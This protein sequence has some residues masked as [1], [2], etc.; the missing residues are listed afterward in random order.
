MISV[1]IYMTAY[2]LSNT[3]F[4]SLLF[5]SSSISLNGNNFSQWRDT[6]NKIIFCL[7]F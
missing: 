7:L 5:P 2:N 6:L 1:H 3:F 4:F